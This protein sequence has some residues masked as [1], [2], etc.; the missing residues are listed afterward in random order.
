MP[1][2]V[3]S[4]SVRPAPTTGVSCSTDVWRGE[5]RYCRTVQVAGL[6]WVR[7]ARLSAPDAPVLWTAS[8]VV[9]D[10]LI[11]VVLQPNLAQ[12]PA[13]QP[14]GVLLGFDDASLATLV[15]DLYALG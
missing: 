10:R 3:S 15:A 1:K 6:L 2:I 11:E 5:A 4:S 14:S 13:R 8:T 12:R 9:E 7:V